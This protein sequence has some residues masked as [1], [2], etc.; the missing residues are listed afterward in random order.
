MY[1]HASFPKLQLFDLTTGSRQRP[2]ASLL[3]AYTFSGRLFFSLGY[4]QNAY[5]A[6]S[7]ELFWDKMIQ[8]TRELMV[9]A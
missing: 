7:V 5:P 2:G 3:F 8:L 1:K 9:E 6:G 4:D